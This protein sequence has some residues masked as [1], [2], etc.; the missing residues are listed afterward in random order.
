MTAH[1]HKDF[2]EFKTFGNV[3]VAF[4]TGFKYEEIQKSYI[5]G[6][7]TEELSKKLGYKKQIYLYFDH[8]YTGYIAPK[9][10]IFFGQWLSSKNQI[11]VKQVGLKF[12]V[13][14][15]LKLVEYAILN[16]NEVKKNQSLITF[17]NAF[18]EERTLSIDTTLINN[19]NKNPMSDTVREI[20]SHKVYRFG[21]ENGEVSYFWQ[22]G[23]FNVFCKNGKSEEMVVLK[24]ESIYQF[25]TIG[26]IAF[27]FDTN[28]TFYYVRDYALAVSKKH[29]IE[30]SED[31]YRIYYVEH[32]G[33]SK[34]AINPFNY[35]KQTTLLYVVESD[36]LIQDLDKLIK[37][38]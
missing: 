24:F 18:N 37:E 25:V 17:K 5:I 21:S 8:S 27:I 3:T 14:K 28:D 35:G 31:Y 12:E 13:E 9:E 6:S 26:P 16:I 19:V 23:M 22:D 32:I 29:L 33:G 20:F 15:S 34:F 38:K 30:N 2:I 1:A 10:F 7:L 4:K 36:R 11:V